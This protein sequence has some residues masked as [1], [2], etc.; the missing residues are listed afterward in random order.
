M[1]RKCYIIVSL[2]LIFVFSTIQLHFD[3]NKTQIELLS[4]ENTD[5]FI[6]YD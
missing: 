1:K 2:L 4:D 5:Y 6:Y 3:E